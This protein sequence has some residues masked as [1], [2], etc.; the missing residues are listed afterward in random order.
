MDRL[1]E[2]SEFLRVKRA[3]RSV[4]DGML[5]GGTRRRVPG[6]RREEVS[7]LALI[8]TTYYTKLERGR[9]RGISAAV[10]D[11]LTA[12]LQLSP[13]ERAYVARLIPVAGEQV[14]AGPPRTPGTG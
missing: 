10:L 4:P 2:L 12:A 9:V 13:E 11:G 3:H 7:Q 1:K 14:P 8:S 5:V 6:L